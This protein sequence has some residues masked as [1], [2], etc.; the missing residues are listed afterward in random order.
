MDA[1]L[2]MG[3]ENL[4]EESQ[5]ISIKLCLSKFSPNCNSVPFEENDDNISE[6]SDKKKKR[7]KALSQLSKRLVQLFLISEQSEISYNQAISILIDNDNTQDSS[8]RTKTR[9]LYDIANILSSIDLI[10]RSN[11]F[12]GKKETSFQWVHSQLPITIGILSTQQTIPEEVN[13]TYNK[14]NQTA[15]VSNDN[16]C[17]TIPSITSQKIKKSKSK[18]TNK[19]FSNSSLT[20]LVKEGKKTQKQINKIATPE[21]KCKLLDL[22]PVDNGLKQNLNLESMTFA[23]I[24]AQNDTPIRQTLIPIK[25][26][27]AFKTAIFPS[28]DVENGEPIYN[29]QRESPVKEKKR[30]RSNSYASSANNSTVEETKESIFFQ[31]ENLCTDNLLVK[32]V[33][34]NKKYDIPKQNECQRMHFRFAS[35]LQTISENINIDL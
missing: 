7:E 25:K 22:T 30:R 13:I 4:P 11:H 6:M 32:I 27:K 34:P 15:K 24:H 3:I 29:F 28:P 21:Q 5:H 26:R 19:N 17:N 23:D 33:Q 1:D 9:R 18:P 35:P 10:R 16:I 2:K 31:N 14:S 12:Q 20:N 8:L